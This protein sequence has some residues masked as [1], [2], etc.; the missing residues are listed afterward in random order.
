[1]P[2]NN[3]YGSLTETLTGDPLIN[4]LLSAKATPPADLN[5]ALAD[6]AV[7]P[8]YASVAGGARIGKF[9]LGEVPRITGIGV[10]CNIA[11]GLVQNDNPDAFTTGLVLQ[12]T[13]KSYN[14]ADALV[15]PNVTVPAYAWKVPEFNQIYDID[16]PMDM[17]P[18]DYALTGEPTIPQVNG[19]YFRLF[20]G[21]SSATA[22]FSTISVDP[23]FAAKRLIMRPM[24]VVEH[25]F[26]LFIVGF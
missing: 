8:L 9:A 7:A 23:L 16:F 25:T 11:D 24:L 14:A 17:S 10:W 20:A 12:I 3:K 1:M 15:Q 18:L 5:L 19:G 21:I 26:P 13:A 6:F 22:K 2:N 4:I